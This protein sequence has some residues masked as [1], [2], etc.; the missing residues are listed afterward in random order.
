MTRHLDGECLFK[1]QGLRLA[2]TLDCICIALVGKSIKTM[3]LVPLESTAPLGSGGC[4]TGHGG[5]D[6]SELDIVETGLLTATVGYGIVNL[7]VGATDC[8][9]S[10]MNLISK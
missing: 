3:L 6:Q 8:I 1:P 9:C 4:G 7:G 2:I 5:H 10:M